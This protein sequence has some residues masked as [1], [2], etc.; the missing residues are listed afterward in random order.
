MRSAVD[1]VC[2]S[3]DIACY[4]G[5]EHLGVLE[6]GPAREADACAGDSPCVGV[7]AGRRGVEDCDSARVERASDI[8]GDNRSEGSTDVLDTLGDKDGRGALRVKEKGE[9]IPLNFL[10]L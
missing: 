1:G 9:R 2:G 3:N 6:A 7:Q 5:E 10:L 4:D 8:G